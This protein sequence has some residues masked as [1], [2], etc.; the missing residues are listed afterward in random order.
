MASSSCSL[1][2]PAVGGGLNGSL[3]QAVAASRLLLPSTSVRASWIGHQ[4]GG[5]GR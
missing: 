5:E 3:N 2:F 1:R 4:G